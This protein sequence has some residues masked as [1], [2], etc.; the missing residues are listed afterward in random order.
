MLDIFLTSSIKRMFGDVVIIF[1][2]DH[3]PCSRT[4]GMET[5]LQERHV[6]S[7]EWSVNGPVENLRWKLKGTVQ[8]KAPAAKTDLVAGKLDS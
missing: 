3:T 5:F 8:E 2:N 4:K 1:Q 7:L 6:M